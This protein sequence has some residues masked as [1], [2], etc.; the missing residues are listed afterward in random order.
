MKLLL[1]KNVAALGIV[2]DVVDVNEGFARNYLLP[3]KLATEPTSSNVRRLADAR[4]QAEAEMA[5]ERAVL[6]SIAKRLEGVEVTIRARANEDGVLYGSVGRKEIAAA[7]AEE[8]HHVAPE[9]IQLHT[10][11]RRLDNL[12]VELRFAA[13]LRSMIKVWVVREKTGDEAD[14]GEDEQKKQAT[15]AG[16][17]AGTHDTG[18]DQ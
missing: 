5:R 17:E 10:P 15:P 7:L 11:L 2:G 1:C 13:D 9:Q 8:G 14:E 12:E 4:R 18:N 3:R 6:E 16:R